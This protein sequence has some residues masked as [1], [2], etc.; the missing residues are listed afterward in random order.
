MY[1]ELLRLTPRDDLVAAAAVLADAFCDDPMYGALFD[2]AEV[3]RKAMIRMFTGVLTHTSRYGEVWTTRR[4]WGAAAWLVP[5]RTD[6]TLWQMVRTGFTLARG[7]GGFPEELRRDYIALFQRLDRERR[8]LMPDPHY[9]L[10]AIGVSPDRQGHGVGSALLEAVLPRADAEGVRTYLETQT[11]RNVAFY[12]R[13]GFEV[14][15]EEVAPE[16]GIL[17]WSMAR[18]ASS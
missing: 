6:I 13:C 1:D 10:M 8:E 2:D 7:M 5:G 11:E 18:H 4:R 15:K 16:L 3:R 12:A 9:Y 14:L 17:L